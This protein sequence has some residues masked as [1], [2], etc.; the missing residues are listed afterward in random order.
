MAKLNSA[1]VPPN[2]AQL[3]EHKVH[4][5]PL[6]WGHLGQEYGA[7]AA[8]ILLFI[9][10]CIFTPHFWSF[11]TLSLNLQQMS[12]TAI[13]AIGMTLVIGTGGIDLSVG[14]VMA[15]VGVLAPLIFLHMQNQ[16]LGN[17]LGFILPLIVA[18]IC[19]VFN[20]W[21]VARVKVQAIIATLIL[22]LAGRGIAQVITNGAG[23]PFT[24]PG[25]Q[26]IGLASFL[27]IPI[28]A[29]L[30]L[31]LVAIFA[32][33]VNKTTLGR[34]IAA[35]GGNASAARLAG[36]PVMRTTWT[37]YI[38]NAVLAGIAGFIVIALT[39]NA[40]PSSIGLNYELNA[41]AAVAIGGTSLLGGKPKIVGTFIGALITQ[42]IYTAL[43][44]N[45]IP[46][47]VSLV[48]NAVLIIGAVY[49]QTQR[50]KV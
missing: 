39:S 28:Q 47:E 13:V 5:R 33:I 38:I 48:A 12:A 1:T 34:Y 21:L 6:H 20:G 15:I 32:L 7:L 8:C 25:F 30:M 4:A 49:L 44:G 50:R 37:V 46:Q 45:N 23:Q 27:R 22:F 41:I 35:I 26:W 14:A 43:V 2:P 16:V 29:Y 36:V 19:G 31:V 40:D 42:L 3:Q 11:Q 17:I 10:N 18:A 9:I 24:D